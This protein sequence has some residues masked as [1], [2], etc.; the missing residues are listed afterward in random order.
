MIDLNSL[1]IGGV[2]IG[3]LSTFF[4][5]LKGY[6]HWFFNYSTRFFVT[7]LRINGEESIYHSLVAWFNSTEYAK[8]CSILELGSKNSKDQSTSLVLRPGPGLHWFKED[9][10]RILMVKTDRPAGNSGGS[11]SDQRIKTVDLTI[12]SRNKNKIDALLKKISDSLNTSSDSVIV[13]KSTYGHLSNEQLVPKRPMES[14]F[15]DKAQKDRL[16]KRLDWFQSSE[17][18]F[19][20]HHLPY[21]IG[22]LFQGL[23]G[24][25]KTSLVHAIASKYDYK[26]VSISLGDLSP[27]EFNSLLECVPKRSILLIEDVDTI[28]EGRKNDQKQDGVSFNQFINILD[29][30]GTSHDQFVI[31]TTNH[32]EKLDPAL[33][34]SGRIDIVLNFGFASDEVINDMIRSFTTDQKIIDEITSTLANET[35]TA[36]LQ[37]ILLQRLGN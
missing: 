28:Y 2:G 26:I 8:N 29:G 23:P 6:G 27:G 5:T 16:I 15:L 18:F 19:R 3:V 7:R 25:G 9:G 36:E 24:T 1:L 21:K 10:L 30:F 37:E 31:M 34:R 32:P 20:K 33:V 13:Y 12:F 4:H 22:C 11:L 14:V 35:T 17:P